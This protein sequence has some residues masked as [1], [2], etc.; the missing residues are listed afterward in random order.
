[1]A[2]ELK[3]EEY[4]HNCHEFE[5]KTDVYSS[6]LSSGL[7]SG[8]PYDEPVVHNDT[9][10]YCEHRERCLSMYNF[11]RKESKGFPEDGDTL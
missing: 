1:M 11:I 2:I 7:L 8:D 9:I 10:V 5:P 6:V 4:C 3:I